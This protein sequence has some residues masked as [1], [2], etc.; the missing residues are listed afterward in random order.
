MQRG[1]RLA[2][3]HASAPFHRRRAVYP[4]PQFQFSDP[5]AAGGP[6]T[7]HQLATF[8]AGLQ[9]EGCV[10]SPTTK[11][12]GC[13]LL[14]GDN[15][16][17]VFDAM[18]HTASVFPRNSPTPIYSNFQIQLL[19]RALDAAIERADVTRDG[20]AFSYTGLYDYLENGLFQELGF[21]GSGFNYTQDIID[22]CAWSDQSP[23]NDYCRFMVRRALRGVPCVR[24]ALTR[25]CLCTRPRAC[26]AVLRVHDAVG[27]HVHVRPR[28]GQVGVVPA[29]WHQRHCGRPKYARWCGVWRWRCGLHAGGAW[30]GA[31]TVT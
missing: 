6:I 18:K 15:A 4:P 30:H 7:L 19:G 23:L 8:Q 28:H 26:A 27:R 10:C 21:T 11:Q 14:I 20:E 24:R 1:P 25:V 12:C 3:I 2:L 22:R 13:G 16:T 9:R 5:Y 29:V 31:T 17:A